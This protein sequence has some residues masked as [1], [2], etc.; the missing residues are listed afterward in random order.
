M[1]PAMLSSD[2]LMSRCELRTT[3]RSG[4]G[5]QH[6]NKVETAVVVQH[7]DSGIA[8]EANE[9]RSQAE[10]RGRAL[11]RLRVKLALA[12]RDEPAAGPTRLWRSRCLRGRLSVNPG[13]DDFP[14]LLAEALDHLATNQGALSQTAAAL[15]CTSSQLTRFLKLEPAALL[16]V[17]RWRQE[18]GQRPLK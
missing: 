4:P 3:R 17:N 15:G 7:R 1:H 14:S 8:A 10:N 12:V 13:H 16:L 9:A 5:G 6:R 11:F 18:S 2:D